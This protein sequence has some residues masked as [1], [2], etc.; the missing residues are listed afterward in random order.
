[1]R[2]R[3][4]L[5]IS[6]G[7]LAGRVWEFDERTTRFIGRSADCDPQLPDDEAHRQVS[8]HHCLVDINPP[9][10]RVRDF[11]SLN[12]TFLNGF[13]IG[14]RAPHHTA[15]QAAGIAFPEHD[16][17]DGDELRIGDTVFRISTV[18][19]AGPSGTR[20]FHACAHCGREIVNA[21]A[22]R[23][24]ASVCAVCRRDPEAMLRDLLERAGAG[25]ERLVPIAGFTVHREIGAGGMGRVYLAHDATGRS[26]A[27]KMMIPVVAADTEA[28]DRFLREIRVTLALDHPRVVPAYHVGCADGLFFFTSEYCPGGNL[29]QHLDRQGGD[30][31]VDEAIRLTVQILE[32][33]E[34]AHGQGFVHRDLT[35]ANILLTADP[36]P[37]V[38]IGDFG[39]AKAFDQAGLSGLT[40]TGAAG[41]KPHFMPY[42]QLVDF[43][44]AGPPVD[45]WAA[46]AC[47]YR[48]LT[49][50]VPRDFSGGRDPW[51]VI[52][53][54]AAVPIRERRPRLPRPLAEVI[55]TALRDRPEIG[56]SSA[57]ELRRALLMNGL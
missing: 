36:V 46:A 31:S 11:G 38:K 29:R 53:G 6:D 18:T 17:N 12:G 56:F 21:D 25:D 49:G 8:R 27:L 37:Q 5:T 48:M 43:R 9:D 35:P 32:G 44:H 3:V 39:L 15:E 13:R 24:G 28:Q 33:L 51:L 41:G 26:V 16:L 2:G 22:G 54:S 14:R 7:A 23:D 4:V 47:L 34:Y 45:V 57:G 19:A 40:R 10:A 52:L 20:V 42:Q 30:L 1:M 50:T 55:D